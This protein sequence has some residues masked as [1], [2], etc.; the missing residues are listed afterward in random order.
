MSPNQSATSERG[1]G[2]HTV[3]ASIDPGDP[4]FRP[5]VVGVSCRGMEGFLIWG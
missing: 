3:R 1:W 4:R 5:E 2:F